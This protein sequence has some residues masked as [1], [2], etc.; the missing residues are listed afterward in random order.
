ME[1]ATSGAISVLTLQT[2]LTSPQALGDE[3]IA[4]VVHVIEEDATPTTAS[5]TTIRTTKSLAVATTITIYVWVPLAY[6]QVM[7]RG[8]RAHSSN[9]VLVAPRARRTRRP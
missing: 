5:T 6:A 4:P 9:F 7:R 3:D 2:L 8:R 1:L